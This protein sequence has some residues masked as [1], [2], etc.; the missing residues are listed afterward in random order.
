MNLKRTYVPRPGYADVV[1]AHAGGLAFAELALL[2]LAPG[3][4]YAFQ[5]RT[6]ETALIPLVGTCAVTAAGLG[7][8]TVG[9][10]RSVFD[11]PTGLVYIPRH[12]GKVE[13]AAVDGEVEVAVCRAPATTA[14]PPRLITAAEVKQVS[15]GEGCY[16]REALMLLDERFAASR[17]FIGEAIVPGGNWASWPPH[18]HDFENPPEEVDMEEIYFFRFDPPHGF[19][20]QRVYTDD[21]RLDAAFAVGNNEAIIIPEGYHPVAAA[22]GARMYY[23][24]VMCGDNRKFLSHKDAAFVRNA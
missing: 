11:G 6:K 3:Q 8:V 9:G 10:R 22:P 18:R 20:F 24:W 12:G 4:T 7:R 2:R 5:A 17:L 14:C 13:V 23:L 16:R 15:I 21:R 19:G 1:K